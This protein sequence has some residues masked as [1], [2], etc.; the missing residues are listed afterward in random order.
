MLEEIEILAK[1]YKVKLIKKMIKAANK[2]SK[3]NVFVD[4][5]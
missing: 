1:K 5:K 4:K 3:L 2:F